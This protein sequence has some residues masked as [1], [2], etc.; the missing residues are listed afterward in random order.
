MPPADPNEPLISSYQNDPD[1]AELIRAFV[2]EMP[3]RLS[4][5]E[6]AWRERQIHQLTRLA[7]QLKG[8]CAGYGFEPIGDAAARLEEALRGLDSGSAERQ[9][10]ALRR[11]F[12]DLM[13]VCSR[14]CVR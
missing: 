8:C 6:A 10:E 9:L 3:G 11:E 5:L 14:A 1:M 12:A 7:H 4:A 2:G 13:E